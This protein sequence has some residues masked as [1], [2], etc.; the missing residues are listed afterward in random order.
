MGLVQL[1]LPAFQVIVP[2]LAAPL[3]MLMARSPRA[4]WAT[5]TLTSWLTLA[6]AL[7]LLIRVQAEG[8]VAYS[9]GGWLP[10]VGIEYR[11]DSV[12]ILVL[13]V[14]CFISAVVMPFARLSVA[15]EVREDKHGYFYAAFLLANCGLL[16]IAITGDAFNIFVFFEI[17]ALASYSLIATGRE[18]QAV[19]ASYQYLM[20]G[21]IGTT[22]LLIGIGFLYIMTGTLNL[23]DLAERLPAVNDTRTVRAALAFIVVG[24]SL[25]LAL[26]PLHLWLPNAYAYAPSMVTVFLSATATK[27]AIYV[28]MRFIFGVFGHELSFNV[29]G[30][31]LLL[32]PLAMLGILI[33]SIV[34]IFHTNIKRMLAYSS[35]AQVGYIILGISFASTLG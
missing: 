18:R 29:L 12:N 35:V 14:I 30:M 32:M 25:K 2:M 24:I 6:I 13:L 4:A 9:M 8:V 19:M 27:V 16:G 3:V 10:P 22:F 1:H 11:V 7:L 17:A 33:P 5:A 20:M 28:L 31:N 23:L 15:S 26:F 34:A 21:T